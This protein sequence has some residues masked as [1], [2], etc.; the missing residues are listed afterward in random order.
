MTQ[1]IEDGFARGVVTGTVCV[2]LSETY[3]TINHK[4]LLNKIYRMT[5]DA[6]FTDL[7][8]NMFYNRRYIFELNGLPQGSV[9]SSVLFNIYRNDQPVQHNT[10]SLIYADDLCI[11]KQDAS[12]DKTE[13]PISAN[14]I[15]L[16]NTMLDTTSVPTLKD[17]DMRIPYLKWRR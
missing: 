3:D 9:L 11:T 1:H 4:L 16:A 6:K 5:Y 7:I 14:Y 17:T 13:S 8:G 10:R 12:I 15:I 2:D